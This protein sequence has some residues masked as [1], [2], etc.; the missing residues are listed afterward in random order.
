MFVANPTILMG[1]V[2]YTGCLGG[3]KQGVSWTSDGE[4]SA[5]ELWGMWSIPSLLLGPLWPEVVAPDSVLSISQIELWDIWTVCKQ[6][7]C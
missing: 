7:T 3:K 2:E 1:D 6:M 5:L 4:V